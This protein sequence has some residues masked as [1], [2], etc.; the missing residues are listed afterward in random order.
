M[1]AEAEYADD[2]AERRARGELNPQ[3]W[4]PLIDQDR[5]DIAL[6]DDP[7]DSVDDVEMPEGLTMD[8]L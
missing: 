3:A 2:L 4:P 7:A 8:D 5:F 6:D 1:D